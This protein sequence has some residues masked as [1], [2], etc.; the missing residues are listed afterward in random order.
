MGFKQLIAGALIGLVSCGT[1]AAPE[2]TRVNIT[3]TG[4]AISVD[5]NNIGWVAEYGHQHNKKA[6]VKYSIY[7]D[8][9]QDGLAVGDYHIALE[10][11]NCDDR[12]SGTKSITTYKKLKNGIMINLLKGVKYE[13]YY[14]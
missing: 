9:L 10:W 2:W 4:L 13:I 8:M 12:T 5:T 11:F 3:D 14:K 7:K 6:W 1:F